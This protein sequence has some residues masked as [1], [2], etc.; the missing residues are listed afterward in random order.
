MSSSFRVYAAIGELQLPVNFNCRR[1]VDI[2]QPS[3]V[4]GRDANNMLGD[5]PELFVFSPRSFSSYFGYIS[6]VQDILEK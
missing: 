1:S 5:S 6:H 4:R 3:Q 2:A